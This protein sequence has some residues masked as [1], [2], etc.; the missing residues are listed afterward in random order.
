M[1]FR[2]YTAKLSCKTV[3]SIGNKISLTMPPHRVTHQIPWP[4]VLITA[5]SWPLSNHLACTV[6]FANLV[7]NSFNCYLIVP[8]L[9][10]L[11]CCILYF[12]ESKGSMGALCV[13][14]SRL[15]DVPLASA[16]A[17]YGW[18]IC[19]APMLADVLDS[20]IRAL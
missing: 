12:T 7:I 3:H 9:R 16:Q 18:N 13:Q 1:I 11:C 5:F 6:D 8:H 4:R 15:A 17:L 20:S 2:L 19:W 14:R 10:G